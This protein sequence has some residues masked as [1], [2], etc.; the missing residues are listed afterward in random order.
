[1]HFGRP[2]CFMNSNQKKYFR[3]MRW[4]LSAFWECSALGRIHISN[5]RWAIWRGESMIFSAK[6]T[7]Y[8]PES[9]FFQFLINIRTPI[10]EPGLSLANW[11]GWRRCEEVSDILIGELT[12]AL[13]VYNLHLGV[14]TYSNTHSNIY[15][16]ERFGTWLQSSF[17]DCWNS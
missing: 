17:H 4:N 3:Q 6:G 9:I 8:P 15:W 16:A 1:M 2:N 5:Y 7:E 10:P 13:A 11:Q 12:R 14:Q